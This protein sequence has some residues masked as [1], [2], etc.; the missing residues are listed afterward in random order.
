MRAAVAEGAAEADALRAQ[1]ERALSE[2]LASVLR[3]AKR[4]Q[5]DFLGLG[6]RLALADPLRFSA[7]ETPFAELLSGLP[8]R[9]S[10]SAQVAH[11]NDLEAAP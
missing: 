11:S 6:E 1:L 10:V 4:E 7:L 2:R 3:V 8:I 9:L 5:A